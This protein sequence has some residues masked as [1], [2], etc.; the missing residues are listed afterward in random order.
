M[1]LKNPNRYERDVKDG[2]DY[3][4][5]KNPRKLALVIPNGM[6]KL[7]HLSVGTYTEYK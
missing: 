1:Y 5:L 7:D 4:A 6:I 3:C 2:D